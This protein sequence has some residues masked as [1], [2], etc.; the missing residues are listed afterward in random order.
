VTPVE[1]DLNEVLVVE[2]EESALQALTLCEAFQ[3]TATDNAG[4]VALRTPS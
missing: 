1:G 2:R 4:R 3:L